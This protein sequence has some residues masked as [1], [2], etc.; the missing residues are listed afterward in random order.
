MT[1][2]KGF[3]VRH[4]GLRGVAI[5][6][7]SKGLLA[8]VAAI[9][10]L[11]LLHKDMH[12][13]AG[14]ILRVLHLNPDRQL[15]RWLLRNIGGITHGWLWIIFC[16]IVLYAII[17]FVEAGGLWLEKEWAEWFALLSGTLYTP[18]LVY[19]L[20][21]HPT[22][23]KWLGLA[24]NLLIVVYLAW[25]LRDSYRRRRAAREGGASG[26]SAD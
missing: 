14:H 16:L 13:V 3:F 9:W 8:V 6:E 11:T 19:E 25:L 4:F 5:F 22:E 12:S 2:P 1:H 24:L 10:V 15:Y 26:Q 21:R 7:A 17:R 20:V 18:F 23:F